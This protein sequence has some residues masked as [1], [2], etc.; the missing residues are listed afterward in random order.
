[1]QRLNQFLEPLM[2]RLDLYQPCRERAALIIWPEI[3]GA[4]V[5]PNTAAVGI[6]R[7]VL[8]VR[9]A[10]SAWMTELNVGYK[11][12]YI[13]QLNRRLGDDVVKDIRFLPPPLPVPEAEPGSREQGLAPQP[14]TLEDE[15]LIDEVSAVVEA[16]ELRLRLRRLMRRDLALRRARLQ[17]GWQP[18]PQ[19]HVLTRD[20][21]A[22]TPCV[23][24]A[25]RIRLGG[26]RR[27]L[28][29]APWTSPMDIRQRFP[30]A[31]LQEYQLVKAHLL[32]SLKMALYA[33]SNHAPPGAKLSGDALGKALRYCMLRFGK[34]PH[35]L[36]RR[37][38]TFALGRALFARYPS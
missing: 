19:C 16:P 34:R 35:E 30:E 28:L 25:R 38:I 7:G 13:D 9:T 36:D 17:A 37:D 33:W 22:C 1:M 21:G 5:A 15:A 18:C 6:K 11:R 14:L 32:K 4:Y 10:S 31:T 23:D 12:A 3:V 29:R 8:F 24:R 27:T 26:I 20:G 2:R